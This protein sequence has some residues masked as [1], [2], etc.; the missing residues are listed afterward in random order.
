MENNNEHMKEILKLKEEL[1]KYENL[2]ENMPDAIQSVNADGRII[3]AN[4]RA[5]EIFG[6]TRKELLSMMIDDLYAPDL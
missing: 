3:F 4:R 6:Y 2:V 1:R 5:T